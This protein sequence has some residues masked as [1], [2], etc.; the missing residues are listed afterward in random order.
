MNKNIQDKSKA[1]NQ[2]ILDQEIVK[3]YQRYE[4]LVQNNQE[5]KA[6]EEELKHL[7]RQIVQAK[8]RQEDCQEIIQEYQMKKKDF[9]ENPLIY[10]Y[11]ALKIEVNTLL[12][13]IQDDINLE[14]KKKSDET[15]KTLYNFFNK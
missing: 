9:D 1:L 11:L 6:L 10:N 4:T 5:L 7:Q 13:Q 14:L 3:E 8:H 15:T 2:W 12:N